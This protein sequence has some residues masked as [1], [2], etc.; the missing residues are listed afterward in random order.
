MIM[1]AHS[2]FIEGFVGEEIDFEFDEILLPDKSLGEHDASEGGMMAGKKIYSAR[3]TSLSRTIDW[4]TFEGQPACLLGIEIYFHSGDHILKSGAYELEIVET[5][6]I[7]ASNTSILHFRP[8][9]FEGK[10]SLKDINQSLE[11]SPNVSAGGVQ[12]SIGNASRS[13][14]YTLERAFKITGSPLADDDEDNDEPLCRGVEW[15]VQENG[16][17]KTGVQHHL[18]VAVL[19]RHEKKPFVIESRVQGKTGSWGEKAKYLLSKKEVKPILRILSPPQESSKVL[20]IEDLNEFVAVA[21]T[22]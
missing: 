20:K 9:A 17:Q 6:K 10:T 3:I 19:I 15:R 11:I 1:Q 12:G 8:E 22:A 13:T 7:S 21:L 2:E 4:G 14:S 16:I 18:R 5:K